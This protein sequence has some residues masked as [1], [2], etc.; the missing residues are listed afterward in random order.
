MHVHHTKTS[1]D[2]PAPE[3]LLV[4]YSRYTLKPVLASAEANAT[5]LDLEVDGLSGL[6]LEVD[7]EGPLRDYEVI[8][9][10]DL[11]VPENLRALKRLLIKKD[12]ETAFAGG[13]ITVEAA[14]SLAQES[15]QSLY[16]GR[17]PVV[18]ARIKPPT[19]RQVPFHKKP[20]L[21][22]CLN[23][24]QLHG[25]HYRRFQGVLPT[26]LQ[27]HSFNFAPCNFTYK[28]P[29]ISN[30]RYPF[31]LH[32]DLAG[33][34]KAHPLEK[35]NA[36]VILFAV[37]LW[38]DIMASPTKCKEPYAEERV[39][40]ISLAVFLIYFEHWLKVHEYL[41]C[42]AYIH[43]FRFID[44]MYAG[45]ILR[46]DVHISKSSID[47]NRVRY[48]VYEAKAIDPGISVDERMDLYPFMVNGTSMVQPQCLS[49]KFRMSPPKQALLGM[50]N[51]WILSHTPWDDISIRK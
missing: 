35:L 21:G 30:M 28:A 8:L 11:T 16:H 32:L 45:D 20:D 40:E 23:P 36:S 5:D 9:H 24:D 49:E 44:H 3:R 12:W 10:H 1:Y 51:P 31:R 37:Q 19:T 14:K 39:P 29:Y 4:G 38:V 47:S 13:D 26:V 27:H 2:N 43:P 18:V 7:F 50:P 33:F 17:P 22:Q 48:L 6:D 15:A 42:I 34:A 25:L 46:R 41:Q